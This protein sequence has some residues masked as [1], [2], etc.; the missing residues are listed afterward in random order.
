MSLDESNPKLSNRAG[1]WLAA[2]PLWGAAILVLLIGLSVLGALQPPPTFPLEQ[3]TEWTKAN[4]TSDQ[5]GLGRKQAFIAVF[6]GEPGGIFA[7]DVQG[8]LLAAEAEVEAIPWVDQW[9]TP[10]DLSLIHI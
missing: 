4:E 5:F 10:W 7:D 1:S 3:G 9:M 8:A 2:R 6:A